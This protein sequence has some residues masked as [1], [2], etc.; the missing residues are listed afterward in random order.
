MAAPRPRVSRQAVAEDGEE[1]EDDFTTVG[2]GGRS[3]SYAA[4]TIFKHLQTIQEARGKKVSILFV[5]VSVMTYSFPQNTDKAEHISILERLLQVAVTPYQRI[6]ILIAL[7]SS[8]FDY[9]SSIS[10]HMSVDLWVSAQKEID[11]L[12]N[13]A[14]SDSR[15][16]VEETTLDYDE[17]TERAPETE[18]GGVVRIRGS[19]ISF[20]DRLDDEFTKGLQNTDPHGTD[21]VERLRDETG[22][23]RT[24]CSAQALYETK[25]QDDPL[26]RVILR[27]L[28]HIYSKVSF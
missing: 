19:I 15:Y 21:Y 6:R 20:V 17:M 16:S 24:I 27:R 4:D 10:S 18:D 23:Y 22:L 12:I 9:N 7:I 28:E 25:K 2:R 14:S 5:T 3:I 1:G 11:Q 13:I 8:R 26:A